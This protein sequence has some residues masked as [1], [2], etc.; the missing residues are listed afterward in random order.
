MSRARPLALVV[1]LLAGCG[2][3]IVG[4]L[5][6]SGSGGGEGT[7]GVEGGTSSSS[8]GDTIG[9]VPPTCIDDDFEDGVIDP[10]LWY[11]WQEADATFQEVAGMLKLD[12]PTF[13]LNDTGVVGSDMQ[14]FP[15]TNGRARM[16]VPL[17]P[18]VAQPEI[19]FLQII[20]GVNDILSIDLAE[21]AVHISGSLPTGQIFFETYPTDPYPQF[22]AVRA[23]GDLFHFETSEDGIDYTILATHD[24]FA[25]FADARALIMAQTYG[26]NAMRTVIGVDDY[27][28]C[29]Q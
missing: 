24:R 17:P 20:D 21:G 6:V 7:S 14:R 28:V 29:V 11:T 8:G 18:A 1:A 16:R 12:P 19:I 13:G 4:Y 5:E 3:E 23:E 9:L 27:E 22:I 25:P 2:D 10:N 26:D 15:F